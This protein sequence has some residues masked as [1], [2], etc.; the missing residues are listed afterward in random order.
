MYNVVH[1]SSDGYLLHF[2][3]NRSFY[4]TAQQTKCSDLYLYYIYSIIHV[5]YSHICHGHSNT[6][7][8]HLRTT[9]TC[10]YTKL[11]VLG[12]PGMTLDG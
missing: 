3:Q 11:T 6:M 5:Q 7:P 1:L 10:L 8:R 2:T 9:Y 4:L 12:L